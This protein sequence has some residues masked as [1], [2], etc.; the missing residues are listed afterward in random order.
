MISVLGKLFTRILNHRLSQWA[1]EYSVYIDGQA[2][3]RS[4]CGT[5]DNIFVLHGLINHFINSG[6]KLYC[7][8]VDFSKAFDYIVHDNLWFK[9]IKLG[10]R[11]K[12]LNVIRSIYRNVKSRVKTNTGIS[13]EFDCVLGV[14]QGECLSPFLF[15][16]FINDLEDHLCTTGFQGIDVLLMKFFV[17]LYAD[18]IVILS[19]SAAGLQK[20]FSSLYDYCQKWK[21]IVNTDKTNVL[22]FKKGGSISSSLKFYYG[23]KD[24]N[25]QQILLSRYFINT[26]RIFQ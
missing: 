7:G 20:G 22:V 4:G 26:G 24:K 1:E 10:L 2:G 14:R 9:L 11:G 19:D 17:L 6:K 21:L 16:M 23:D 5:V 15:A 3:F 8:F 25:C 18:D 12:I 13:D